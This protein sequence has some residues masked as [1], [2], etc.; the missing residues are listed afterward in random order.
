MLR[1]CGLTFDHTTNYGS[2]L[3][4]YALSRVINTTVI[5]EEACDYEL[6]PL[7]ACK[8]FPKT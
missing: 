4:A 2:C 1:V 3:Q 5:N 7:S 6:I 8:G